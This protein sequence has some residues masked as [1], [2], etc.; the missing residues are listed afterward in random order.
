MDHVEASVLKGVVQLHPDVFAALARYCERH[1]DYLDVTIRSFDREVQFYLAYLEH[2]RRFEPAGLRF[3]YPEISAESKEVRARNTFDLAL[4]GRLVAEGSPVVCNDFYL[5]EP[6][7]I[8]VV[9]GPNQGR[10]TTF[11]RTFGQLHHLASP[12]CPVPGTEAQLFVR[13]AVYPLR[14]G[15]GHGDLSGKLSVDLQRVHEI[16]ERTTPD[17]IVIMNESFSSTTP[18][19]AVFLGTNVL[20]E[21]IELDLLGVRVT[22]VDELASLSDTTVSMVSTIV[23]GNPAPRTYK[24]ERRPGD[25]LAYAAVIAEQYGL[26]YE[27]LKDRI[28]S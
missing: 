18:D 8:V 2:K 25:G 11:A 10:K 3:A 6:E 28:A 26:S 23:H 5:E 13:R 20:D 12:G 9:T 22:F 17:N 15:R 4:A 1:S 7:R 14:E 21:L 27:A 24:I 19:D 16:L